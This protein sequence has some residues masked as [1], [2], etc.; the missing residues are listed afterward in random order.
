MPLSV[1][2]P[3]TLTPLGAPEEE[4]LC[5]RAAEVETILEN[6]RASRLTVVTSTSGLGASSLLRAG[7]EP[8]LRREGFVTVIYS[9]WQGRSVA[10]RLR[11]AIVSAVHEQTDGGFIPL[12]GQLLELLTSAQA[13]IGRPI[14]VLLDQFEDYVRCHAGTDVSDDFDAELANA[15]S[16]RSGRFVIALQTPSVTAF[17]RLSQYIPN[18]MGFTINLPPLTSE[19]AKDLIRGTAARAGIEIEPAAVDLLLATPIAAVKADADRPAG[20]HPLFVKLGAERL[21]EAE[22]NLKSK[23]ARASTLQAN[24]GADRLILDSLDLGLQQL[25]ATHGELLFRWIPLLLTPDGRR[26]DVSEK[27]LLE[28]AG[29][30]NRF[31]MTLLPVLVKSGLIR[32]VATQAGLRYEFGRESTTVVVQDWWIRAEALIVA[33]RRAQFR[34]RSISIAVGAIV[35]LYVAYLFLKR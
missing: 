34:V 24:G 9:D 22:L 23:V 14:A 21:L 18:L 15:I 12:P 35:L 5:G 16:T 13:K 29:K 28:H 8:V 32:T 17:E 10:S 1:P 2:I 4:L 6:C 26:A 27:V 19:A 31:A 33:R 3:L 25:G 11:E 20:V 7:A 30:W